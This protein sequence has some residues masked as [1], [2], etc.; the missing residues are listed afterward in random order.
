VGIAIGAGTDVAI[1]C[2]DVV[3]TGSSLSGVADAITLSRR[4]I[5]CIRENLFWALFYNSICIPL[6][7]GVLAPVGI[8]LNPMI[9]AAAMSLSSVCVVLNSLRLKKVSINRII[10]IK[11]K[12][13]KN[14]EVNTMFNQ[15]TATHELSVKGMMCQHCVAHVRKALEGVG[16]V[17]SVEISLENGTATVTAKES[18]KR[19]KLVA[20]VAA[21]GYECE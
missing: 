3:L 20:A 13:T 11:N 14:C 2:A 9:A 8:T 18:V 10:K 6:A 15:K 12:K 1:D 4:T 21:Q 17:V 7:A 16:G 5:A 19:E